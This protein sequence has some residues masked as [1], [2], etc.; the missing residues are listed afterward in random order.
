MS[1]NVIEKTEIE[2][3]VRR[4]KRLRIATIAALLAHLVAGLFMLFVLRQGLETA[5][6]FSERLIFLTSHKELWI[7]GWL[8]WIVA[9]I[10]I[11]FFYYSFAEAHKVDSAHR[12][13][14]EQ[15]GRVKY[16]RHSKKKTSMS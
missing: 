9:A 16:L 1:S 12:R 15:D 4:W 14:V 10:S 2:E 11:F 3:A 7:A 13:I 6:S 5:V 8:S